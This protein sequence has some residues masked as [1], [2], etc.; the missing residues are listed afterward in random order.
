M[1]HWYNKSLVR[2]MAI[3]SFKMFKPSSYNLI[4]ADY[5]DYSGDFHDDF[6]LSSDWCS[7]HLNKIDKPKMEV[8]A[9]KNYYVGTRFSEF[10]LR[11]VNSVKAC[12]ESTLEK[13]S[14]NSAVAFSGL[15]RCVICFDSRS[16]SFYVCPFCGRYLGC[17]SC[18]SK[19]DKCPLCRK[20]F[21]CLKCIG[22][23]QLNPLF[24]PDIEKLVDIPPTTSN[25]LKPP[26]ESEDSDDTLPAVGFNHATQ[27]SSANTSL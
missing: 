20:M 19:V 27:P 8:E 6:L 18:L 24:M 23:L 4:K 12:I 14:T 15:L 16:N 21:S 3:G 5:G 25:A 13:S 22:I 2:A 17:F 10:E 1:D 11:I 9:D 26:S 7:S